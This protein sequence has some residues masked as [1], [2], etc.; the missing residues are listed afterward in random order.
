MERTVTADQV[1]VAF[2]STFYQVIESRK[3]ESALFKGA[4]SL[5]ARIE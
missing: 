2:R 3:Q 4:V 1:S 5:F